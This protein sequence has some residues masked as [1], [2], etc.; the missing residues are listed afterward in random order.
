[1]I[2]HRVVPNQPTIMPC[3]ISGQN[4]SIFPGQFTFKLVIFAASK[5]YQNLVLFATSY[6]IMQWVLQHGVQGES[7]GDAEGVDDI[8]VQGVSAQMQQSV[9]QGDQDKIL[10]HEDEVYTGTQGVSVQMPQS[11]VQ[12]D[13]DKILHENVQ[14]VHNGEQWHR[15][16]KATGVQRVAAGGFDEEVQGDH[17]GLQY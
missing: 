11:V 9:I 5:N 13:N 15:I 17:N 14:G 1:M 6:L 4:W 10:Q 7:D 3:A 8:E 2:W 12:G 16:S